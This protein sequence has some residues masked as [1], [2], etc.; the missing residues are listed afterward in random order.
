MSV[1]VFL[2][3]KSVLLSSVPPVAIFWL[4]S[5]SSVMQTVMFADLNCSEHDREKTFWITLPKTVSPVAGKQKVPPWESPSEGQ[6]I[7]AQHLP[8]LPSSVQSLS[9]VQL[10]DPMDCSTPGLPVHHHLPEFT[11][12]RVH[13]VGDAIQSSHPLSSPSPAFNL[14]QHQGLFKSSKAPWQITDYLGLS[15]TTRCHTKQSGIK[16]PQ[17]PKASAAENHHRGC[18]ETY[19]WDT[20]DLCM[21]V[22]HDHFQTCS[23]QF[24]F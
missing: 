10:C 4:P 22:F 5:M 17:L 24:V 14:S 11:Q 15:L 21:I 20:L 7:K 3:Q 6:V 1:K 9:R 19:S 13:W 16:T 18:K 2:N 12:T 8:K 23:W